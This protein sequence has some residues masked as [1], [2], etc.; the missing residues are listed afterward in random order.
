[1]VTQA[2]LEPLYME[3][4][5]QFILQKQIN[6]TYKLQLKKYNQVLI[7]QWYKGDNIDFDSIF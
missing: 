4:S 6:N 1:M 5:K 2:K 7:T 3:K